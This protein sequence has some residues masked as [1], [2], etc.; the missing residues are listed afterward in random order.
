[1]QLNASDLMQAK[2]KNKGS[3]QATINGELCS[4]S[5]LIHLIRIYCLYLVRTPNG[6]LKATDCSIAL[7][8]SRR[9]V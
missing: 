4:Y 2:I 5:D 1:M 7:N 9:L 3:R 6:E 8:G